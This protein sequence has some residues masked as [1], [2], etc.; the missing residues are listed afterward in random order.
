M[1]NW[2]CPN[3]GENVSLRRFYSDGHATGNCP[4]TTNQK[5][6]LGMEEE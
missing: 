3:C 1:R 4:M 2:R 6:Q 5:K